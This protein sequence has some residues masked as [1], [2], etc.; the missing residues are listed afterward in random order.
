[1][2]GVLEVRGRM[3]DFV[4]RV[5]EAH[6]QGRVTDVVNIGIG[7]SDLGPPPSVWAAKFH[8]GPRT[9]L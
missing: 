5:H 6:A 4:D 9:H 3:L 2:P 7:G 1:M 8:G